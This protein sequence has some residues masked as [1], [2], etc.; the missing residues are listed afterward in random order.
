[1]KRFKSSRQAQKF[2]SIHDQAAN[3]F[4]IHRN[5]LSE[6]DHCAT[7]AGIF[8]LAAAAPLPA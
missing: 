8:G 3:L 7:R 6:T 1:M 4:H 2:L 5:K